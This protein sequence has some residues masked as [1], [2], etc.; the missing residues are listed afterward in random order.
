VNLEKT[1][2]SPNEIESLVG[3]SLVG[4]RWKILGKGAQLA[5][6]QVKL[7]LHSDFLNKCGDQVHLPQSI[8]RTTSDF[9][10]QNNV[11]V[12]AKEEGDTEATSQSLFN[13]LSEAFGLRSLQQINFSAIAK[14]CSTDSHTVELIIREI[15]ATMAYLVNKGTSININFKVG[16]FSVRNGYMNFK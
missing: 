10:G 4:K 5:P 1:E 7:I 12:L 9:H 16:L 2:R 8:A 13:S 15:I 3:S 11:V 14:S 6:I